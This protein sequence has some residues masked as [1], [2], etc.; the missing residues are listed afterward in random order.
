M[1]QHQQRSSID[2]DALEEESIEQIQVKILL[3]RIY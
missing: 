1:L 2:T 3:I